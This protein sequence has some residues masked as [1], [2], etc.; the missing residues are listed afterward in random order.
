LSIKKSLSDLV[1][2]LGKDVAIER[3]IRNVPSNPVPRQAHPFTNT[4]K[5]FEGFYLK[6]KAIIWL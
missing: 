5:G 2:H 6:A 1:A 4:S 3:E